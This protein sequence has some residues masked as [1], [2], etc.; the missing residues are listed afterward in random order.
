MEIS[1][2]SFRE[3]SFRGEF[4]CIQ[5]LCSLIF[6]TDNCGI[7]VQYNNF[8]KDLQGLMCKSKRSYILVN[9]DQYSCRIYLNDLKDIKK[10][11]KKKTPKLPKYDLPSPKFEQLTDIDL[12]F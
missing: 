10:V 4:S 8:W 11:P 12:E 6:T 7:W 9:V 2:L 1:L 5:E 3:K